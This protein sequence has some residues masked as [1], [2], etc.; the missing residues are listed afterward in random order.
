M[1]VRNRKKLLLDL[2][3]TLVDPAVGIISSCRH[4]LE[5]LGRP[6]GETEDLRWIIGPPLRSSFAQLLEGRADPEEALRLYRERYVATGLYEA[7]PYP[8]MFEA[9]AEKARSGVTLLLCT[10]KPAP[11]ARRV[12]EHFGFGPL[13]S[14]VYGPD[15][16]GRFDDK[17]DLIEHLLAAETLDPEQVCMVGDR[18]HDVRAATRHGIPTVGVLWGYGSLAELEAA[19]AEV[20]IQNPGELSARA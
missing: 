14:A 12:V 9:L 4:A 19:G 2:D 5:A 10:A 16:D 18:E 3:G 7:T 6:V 20:I 11:F 15:L 1:P 8:G 13:L 17:G